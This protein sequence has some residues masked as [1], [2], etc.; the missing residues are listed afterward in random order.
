MMSSWFKHKGLQPPR[1]TNNKGPSR[2]VKETRIAKS[3]S[4]TLYECKMGYEHNEYVI[5]VKFWFK[6][7]IKIGEEMC[8]FFLGISIML[9]AS[10]P[11]LLKY[12]Y[13]YGHHVHGIQSKSLIKTYPRSQTIQNQLCYLTPSDLLTVDKD[14]IHRII[15]W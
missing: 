13:T 6:I 12:I 9:Y 2:D 3:V 8:N 14:M 11:S 5:L 1:V 15:D 10:S 7:I 4:M